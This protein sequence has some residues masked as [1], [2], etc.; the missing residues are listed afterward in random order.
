MSA[1]ARSLTASL[2]D[3]AVEPATG[4]R[5]RSWVW[6][7]AGVAALLAL[8]LRVFVVQSFV[9]PS[10]SM[11]PTLRVGDRVMV[12][13][14]HHELHRG[15]V[16][17]FDGTGTFTADST[18]APSLLAA[19]GRG[20]G[21]LFGLPIG[22][23][24]YVKRVIGLPGDRIMCCDATGRL[25]INGLPATEAYLSSGEAPSTISFD[26]TVPADRIWV[27]GDHRSDSADSR[28]H[29]GDPG[30]G[31]VPIDNVVGPV[32]TVWWP[33]TRAR[34]ISNIDPL[35]AGSPR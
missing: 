31:M 34:A 15:D 35:A 30:G 10:S 19:A 18:P 20:I 2:V 21:A 17:V 3:P 13:R 4:R 29:L 24:D 7:L 9:I 12:S 25:T 23:H 11:D 28:A 8:L 22:R 26:V 1:G 16:V 14:W 27:M 6:G 33:M 32:T 5:L